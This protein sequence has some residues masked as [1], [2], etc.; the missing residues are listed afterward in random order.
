LAAHVFSVL[1]KPISRL[2]INAAVRMAL[3]ATYDWATPG[4]FRLGE[5]GTP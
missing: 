3:Q 4:R 1:A 2:R 5:Q